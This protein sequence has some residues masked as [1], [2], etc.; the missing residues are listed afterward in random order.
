[1][2]EVAR[3]DGIDEGEISTAVTRTDGISEEEIYTAS[4]WQLM[5]WRF[6]KHKLA[7]ISLVVLVVFYF[8]AI[9]CEFVAPY[10]PRAYDAGYRLAPP[11][12]LRIRDAQGNFHWPFVYDFVQ[13][14]DPETRRITYEEDIGGTRYPIQLFVRGSQYKMWGLWD[15]DIHLFGV[16]GT[17][18]GMPPFFLLGTDRLGRDM[19]SRIV[20]GARISLSIG[21]VGVFLSLFLGILL[22]GL[23]GYFGGILDD[24]IQRVIELIRSIPS[25]PLWMALSAAIPTG[26][27]IVRVYFLI[28]IV[29]S[30][31]GWTWMAR[32]VRGRFLS[33]RSEDFVLA[34]RLVGA[35]EM[36]VIF[37]H[38]L[39]SF[40]SYIIAALTLSIPNMILAETALS[41]I[42]VGL[43]APAISW[44]VLLQAAQNV[45]VLALAPWLLYPGVALVIAVLAFNFVGDGLRDAADPYSR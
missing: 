20:T 31:V 12:T 10:D 38:M 39:P 17:E 33:L 7:M 26:W 18:E 29:L 28:T 15:M 40:L 23:S 27:P 19:F 2:A 4:Q 5:W 22:G 13:I 44:G 41:F 34:S 36:R 30:F 32:V 1:M 6:R 43:R 11:S 8:V 25:I 14:R 16:P 9:F 37:R 21:L 3:R 42:G 35:S 24:V 45:R